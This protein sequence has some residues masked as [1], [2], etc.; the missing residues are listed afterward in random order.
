LHKTVRVAERRTAAEHQADAPSIDD[1]LSF[2]S[3]L[4]VAVAQMAAE[5]ALDAHGGIDR[6]WR[7][8]AFIV[9]PLCGTTCPSNVSTVLTDCEELPRGVSSPTQSGYW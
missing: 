6:Y 4:R 1:G 5:A 7:R 3:Q 8:V 9:G 2:K